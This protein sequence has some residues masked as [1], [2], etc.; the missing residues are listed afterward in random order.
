MSSATCSGRGR[1]R[2]ASGV[3]QRPGPGALLRRPLS[4]RVAEQDQGEQGQTEKK[5]SSVSGDLINR[6]FD[7]LC[8]GI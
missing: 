3:G 6:L 8:G 5:G 2:L 1:R 4:E 7:S